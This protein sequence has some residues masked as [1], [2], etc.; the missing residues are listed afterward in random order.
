MFG[1]KNRAQ[2]HTPHNT[3]ERKWK[4][5]RTFHLSVATEKRNRRHTI[6][7][8]KFPGQ[9]YFGAVPLAQ[10]YELPLPSDGLLQL[11]LEL[12]DGEVVARFGAGL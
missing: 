7:G 11:R 10:T 1:R 4:V 12:G 6:Y 9:D 5:E 8:S 3:T 2:I